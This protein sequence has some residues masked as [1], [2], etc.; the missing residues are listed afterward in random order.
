MATALILY[1]LHSPMRLGRL[2]G[3]L[4]GSMLGVE[5]PGGWAPEGLAE[6]WFCFPLTAVTFPGAGHFAEAKCYI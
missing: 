1:E 2:L 6:G 4:Q 5:G 3:R